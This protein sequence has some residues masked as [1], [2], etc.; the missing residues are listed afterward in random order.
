MLCGA[1]LGLRAI[2]ARSIARWSLALI[3]CVAVSDSI[4]IAIGRSVVPEFMTAAYSSVN[5]V[6][7]FAALVFAAPLSEEIFFRGF[8]LGALESSGLSLVF[9]GVLSS[10]AWAAMH[11]QYD[12]YGIATIFLMGLLLAAARAKTGSLGMCPSR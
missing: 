12:L 6:L 8:V 7:L 11:T 1:F 10:L 2:D 9:A 3:A 5:P 4:T